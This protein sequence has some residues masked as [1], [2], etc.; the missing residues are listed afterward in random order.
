MKKQKS[1]FYLALGDSYTIGESLPLKGNFPNQLV[2]LLAE[3]KIT[4]HSPRII[5]KTGWT[6]DELETGIRNA[7]SIEPFLPVYDLVSLL[8]GVND[9]Y[10]GRP[11]SEY[12]PAFEELLK[13][14]IRFAGNDTSHVIVLSIPDWGVSPFAEGRDREKIAAEINAYNQVNREITSKYKVHYIDI[15]PSTREAAKDPG[16]LAGDGLHPSAKEYSKWAI[17]LKEYVKGLKF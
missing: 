6:T 10:R 5:A 17:L 11:V 8:I 4:F 12:R 2:T 7:G 15:T 3:D 13:K 9:Q 1:L 16:L 14:A